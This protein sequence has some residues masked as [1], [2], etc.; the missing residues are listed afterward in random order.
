MSKDMLDISKAPKTPAAIKRLA[1]DL[2]KKKTTAEA[3]RDYKKGDP[4]E[5]VW[6]NYQLEKGLKREFKELCKKEKIIASKYLRACIRLLIS[7]KGDMKK[8]LNAVKKLDTDS[9]VED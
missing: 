6:D 1:Q 7:K 4:K 5:K 3:S 8:A 2:Y 9:L